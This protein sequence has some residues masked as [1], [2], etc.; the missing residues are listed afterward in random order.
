[1]KLDPLLFSAVIARLE[2]SARQQD[3]TLAVLVGALARD[4]RW[5]GE[6]FRRL[7]RGGL[8]HLDAATAAKLLEVSKK[9]I[10]GATG[11]QAWLG[12]SYALLG[13]GAEAAA[14]YERAV[15]SPRA[16]TDDWLRLALFQSDPARVADVLERAKSKVSSSQHI[17]LLASIAE[18]PAVPKGWTPELTTDAEKRQFA[19]ASL[20]VKLA[21]YQREEAVA[22]LEAFSADRTR[23]KGDLAWARRNLA[24]LYA[25]QGNPLDRKR[26]KDLLAAKDN[27]PGETPDEQ[28]ATAA[29]LAGLARQLE[30]DDRKQVIARAIEIL[31][32]VAAV[33][34]DR[35]D[36]FL[37]A[38]INRTSGEREGRI[39]GRTLLLELLKEDPKN[40]DYLAAGLEEATE[41]QDREFADRCAENLLK[42]YPAEFR[43]VAAVARYE[44]RTGRPERAL[45]LANGY[46]RTAD[47]TPG[48]LQLRYGRTAELL[49]ELARTTGV[50]GTPLGRTM[51]DSAADKYESLF[52]TRPD[53]VVA[54]A[55]LLAA[56]GRADAAFAKIERHSKALPM[57]VKVM[58]GLAVLRSGPATP[59]QIALVQEWLNVAKNGE[60]GSIPVLLNEAEFCNLQGNSAGAEKAYEAVLALEERN[61]VALNNLAW[62]LAADPRKAERA[63][64]LLALAV[65]EVGLT[66]ELLDTRA[67][68]KIAARQFEAAERD[69]LQALSQEKTPLRYFHLALA[70]QGQTP[71]RKDEATETFRK[72]KSKGL[73]EQSVHPADIALFR[74]LTKDGEPK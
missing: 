67:R 4:Y 74:S 27:S 49:D 39:R 46:A 11:E 64:E 63:A 37:L 33:T 40:I 54:A 56:D 32:G 14:S 30:S 43:A 41:P 38:Q 8:H 34:K 60:P 61:V 50:R 73:K 68:I 25:S 23:P 9:W 70:M 12:D 57:R 19:Q 5:N 15:Q 1:M 42:N 44:L 20:A 62:L 13:N 2:V 24:M 55:G 17:V 59:R 31:G 36:R 16:T 28:R 6:P 7:I 18:C 52:P 29:V 22:L 53:A 26:A 47:S 51:T 69:L 48:D 72:A 66:G 10:E 35:R 71:S 45:E 58:A 21:R 3:E 65:R